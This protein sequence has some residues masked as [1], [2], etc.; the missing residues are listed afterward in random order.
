MAWGAFSAIDNKTLLPGEDL[1]STSSIASSSS[2][3]LDQM[4]SYAGP[5]MG[6]I[7]GIQ[8]GFGSYYSAK[9]TASNLQF[10][11][12]MAAINARM[13]ENTAQSILD[14]GNR[15]QSQVSMRAGKVKGS[16]KAGQ[17]AR[18]IAIGVGSAAEEVAGTDLMKEM[19]MMTINANATRQAW[20]ARTQA[21]NASN[22]SLL[23]GT[24]AASISPFS[25][26][27]TSLINSGTT[28]ASSWYR[29]RKLDALADTLGVQ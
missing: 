27:S 15:A 16:Q 24:T 11:S 1:G 2:M 17:G 10:Q 12:D 26:A 4:M 21:V 14:A 19:D 3:T 6:I 20:A 9:S 28:V 8:S 18:G 29:N 22:E 13:A 5:I 7:G 23:K 25:A